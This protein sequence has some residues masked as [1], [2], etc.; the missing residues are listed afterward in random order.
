M[1]EILRKFYP[2]A[3]RYVLR[4]QDPNVMRFGLQDGNVSTVQQTLL[5]NLS[6]S[7]VA[8]ITTSNQR[9]EIGDLIMVEIPIPNGEQIA[10]WARVVRLQA[11]EPNRWWGKKDDFF[12]ESR[13]L[14]AAT[15]EP[16]PEG[17]SRALRKGIDQSFLKAMRDQRYRNFMY[18]KV[19]VLEHF[20]QFLAYLVLTAIA[21]G[22]LY[23]WTRP[24]GNYVEGRGSN[25]GERFKF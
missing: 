19:F 13:V 7:G 11:Y 18:Y 9:F 23:W 17:H 14:V 12:N 16:L 21:F 4:A 8:F 25:W 2:R 20:L 24:G 15:F 6:E 22:L 1:A 3:P 10:W 5:M